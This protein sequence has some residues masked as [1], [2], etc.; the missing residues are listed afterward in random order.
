MGKQVMVETILKLCLV[1]SDAIVKGVSYD[2]LK[3]YANDLVE[4]LRKAGKEIERQGNINI[5][6]SDRIKYLEELVDKL[7][8][9][10]DR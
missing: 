6:Q 7:Q 2:Q 9:K 1:V 4:E 8:N 3:G 5:K 10:G